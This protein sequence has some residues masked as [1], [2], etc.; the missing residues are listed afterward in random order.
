MDKDHKLIVAQDY[1][2]SDMI[3]RAVKKALSEYQELLMGSKLNDE[4]IFSRKEAAEFLKI[5]TSTLGRWR[6]AGL[7]KPCTV[8]GKVLYKQADL[9]A[10]LN[11]NTNIAA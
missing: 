6:T 4:K 7:V 10:A 5:S 9:L 8:H 3:N 11:D 1:E 2:I